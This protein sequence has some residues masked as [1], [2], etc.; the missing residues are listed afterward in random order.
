[1]VALIQQVI[2][3]FRLQKLLIWTTKPAINNQM[4]YKCEK[5]LALEYKNQHTSSEML[6]KKSPFS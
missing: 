5:Q 4:L 6:T 2:E 3:I 1:M